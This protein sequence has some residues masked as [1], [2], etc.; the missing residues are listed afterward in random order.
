MEGKYFEGS[1][2]VGVVEGN[3]IVT[4]RKETSLEKKSN[5]Q[6]T[7]AISFVYFLFKYSLGVVSQSYEG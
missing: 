2:V 1:V 7:I 3:G 6:I 5:F 4:L